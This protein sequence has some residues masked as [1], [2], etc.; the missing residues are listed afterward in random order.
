[1]ILLNEI[2]INIKSSNN[3]INDYDATTFE[4]I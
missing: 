3:S 1:M 4:R 2:N